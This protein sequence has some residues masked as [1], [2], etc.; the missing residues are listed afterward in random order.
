MTDVPKA[1]NSGRCAGAVAA[2]VAMLDFVRQRR[3][4]GDQIDSLLC[5]DF[6]LGVTNGQL[7]R[8]VT[9]FGETHPEMTHL[10]FMTLALVALN[11]T[12]PCKE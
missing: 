4:A 1:F 9:R 3:K 5:A 7:V 8:V 12:W 2:I 6:P 10:P 11:A